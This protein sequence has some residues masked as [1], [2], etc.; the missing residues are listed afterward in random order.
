MRT[1]VF[2]ALLSLAACAAVKQNAPA[3]AAQQLDDAL[4]LIAGN[5]YQ[6]GEAAL[7]AV[8]E[9]DTFKGLSGD[10]QYR[11]LATAGKVALTRGDAKI[12]Y[13]YLVRAL[14]MPQASYE[15][16]LVQLKAS[17][18]LGYDADTVA[19][20]TSLAQRWP[21]RVATLNSRVIILTLHKAGRLPHGAALSLMQA[22]YA[23]HWKLPGQI[24]PS[25]I[26]RE[27]VLQLVEQGRIAEAID[28]STRIDDVYDLIALR[29][30]HRYDAVVAANPERFDIATAAGRELRELQ[31]ASE[32]A[33]RL[34]GLRYSLIQ[35][36]MHQQHY[37]AALAAADSLLT[38]TRSTNFPERLYE[39]YGEWNN[40]LLD[41][42]ARAL[43]RF[44][45]W[46]E[47]V[48]QLSAGGLEPEDGGGNVSQLI[49]LGE[50]YCD[51]GRPNDALAAIGRLAANPSPWGA[52]E[53]EEVRFDAALQ[54]GDTAQ[55][56]RSLG[57][58]REHRA[59]ALPVYQHAL[60]VANQLEGAAQVL[61][62]RLLDPHQRQAALASVQ[63][64]AQAPS[65]PRV[66]DWRGRH[67]AVIARHE[68]QAAIQNVGRVERYNLE[69][70]QGE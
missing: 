46:D 43:E 45:R 54:M 47:A 1:L 15:D 33:P 27:L 68:V 21:D 4:A 42:R 64:Y 14:A 8:I 2:L 56:E 49:N 40:W 53:R 52:M 57:Y 32:R 59:D 9:A 23:A 41:E 26:W 5:H 3:P 17:V 24:E 7:T 60:I 66:E 20:L 16:R 62:A 39:D 51:L 11:A 55:A 28:V 38:E 19:G 36:L 12:G 69:T 22:L 63:F 37:A 61:V 13:G 35:A 30:D 65:T 34:L 10:A 70:E 50:L 18:R 58:L 6:E 25:G 29:V 44:G 31:S 67:R 48:A